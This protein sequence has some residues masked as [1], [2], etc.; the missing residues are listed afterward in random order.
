MAA[1]GLLMTAT[2][3]SASATPAS[4]SWSAAGSA[5]ASGQTATLAAP[6]APSV[7]EGEH[8]SVALSWTRGG[9]GFAPTGYYVIRMHGSTASPACHSGPDA[10]IAGLSCIDTALV[11]G[12]STFVVTAVYRSWTAA[13]RPSRE[14]LV[15]GDV[16]PQPVASPDLGASR[17]YSVLAG[18]DVVNTGQSSISGDLGVSPGA[19]AD[20]LLADSVAGEIHLNDASSLAAMTAARSAAR[21]L[22]GRSTGSHLPAQLGGVTLTPGSYHSDDGLQLTGTLTLDAVGDA[23]AVFVL[24][25][26][27]TLQTAA[28]S[29][30][31]LV[32][33]AQASNVFWRVAGTVQTGS[34]S[35]LTGTILANGA[36]TLGQRTTLSGRA[37]S[38]SSVS[39]SAANLIGVAPR[40]P[41]ATDTEAPSAWPSG[42][43]SSASEE[44]SPTPSDTTDPSTPT[45]GLLPTAEPTTAEPTPGPTPVI[46]LASVVMA[47]ATR[48][49]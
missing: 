25:S 13:G 30:V 40:S 2:A 46:T 28:A 4:A 1:T 16:T 45:V 18:T 43:G 27:S 19:S 44:P 23:S 49:W 3:V 15:S 24:S 34:D 22:D 41:A 38:L 6:S 33:G 31:H 29:N 32:N 7:I 14:L 26:D 35:D 37:L 10:L 12:S 48:S 11:P 5:T 36:I 8:S 21:D 39:L 47:I 17:D 9:T 42:P 20:G